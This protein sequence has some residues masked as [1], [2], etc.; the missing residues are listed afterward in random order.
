MNYYK[1]VFDSP[2][3]DAVL[4][5]LE[6][7]VN[8]TKVNG[9]DPNSNAAIWKCAQMALLQRIHNQLNKDEK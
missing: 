7:I 6:R 8:M 2:E 9:E 1:L 4:A 5:D 3:G